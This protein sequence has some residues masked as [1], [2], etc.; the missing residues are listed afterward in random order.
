MN[1]FE[2]LKVT[3]LENDIVRFEYCPDKNFSDQESLFVA[4]KVAAINQL[5]FKKDKK[6][7]FK[8]SDFVFSFD[9]NDPLNTLEVYLNDIVVY[10]YKEIKNSGELPVPNKTPYV[11][12]LMDSPRLLIPSEGY[13]NENSGYE[14]EENVKDL[15]LLLCNKDYL[16]L[17]RQ[18]IS[19]TGKNELPRIKNFGLFSSRYYK[20]SQQSAMEMIRNYEKH[21]IPL[22]TF[23]LDTDWRDQE[24]TQGT[25]YKVNEKLFPNIQDFFRF[26]HIHNLQIMMNDH[27][28]PLNKE[29]KILDKDEIKFRSSNLT[30]LFIKGLDGW[31]YDR[32]W[33]CSLNSVH[34]HIAP[35]TLGN[36]LYN[37]VTKQFHL[38]YVIDQEVY[39]RSLVMNNI[40][41]IEN[42]QYKTILDSRSHT[43]SLQWSG[44]T[45]SDEQTLRN[46][47]INLNKCANN[48]LAFYSSDIGG[49]M[50]NP[51][52]NQYIRWIEY[53]SF[54]PVLR[55][56]CTCSVKKFRE[57]WNYDKKTLEISRNY[58]NIRYKLLNSFY[59]AAYK[60]VES[61]LGVCS[62]LYLYNPDDKKCYKE[63]TSFMI[64]DSILVSPISGAD[65]P[66]SV[67]KSNFTNKLRVT[68]YPNG[69]FKGPKSYTKTVSSFADVNKFFKSVKSK[70]TKAKK[71]SFRFKG[72]LYFKRD[73]QLSLFNDVSAKVS[74]NNK[75]VF[76]DF[77]WHYPTFNEIAKLK[78]NKHYALKV[79]VVQSRKL[80]TVNLVYYK[81]LKNNKTKIYLPEGEWFNMFHKNVYQ[82]KRY[83]KE[84]FKIDETPVFVKAGSLLAL[85]KTV[86]NISKMSLKNIVYDYYTSKK[87]DKTDYFYE[88][89]GI[90]TGYQI[91]E[92][93]KN[94]YR[95]HF[96]KDRYIIELKGNEKLLE[97]EIKYRNVIFKAHIR[98]NETIDKV[99][100]NGEPVKFRRHDHSKKAIPFLDNEFAKDS[101]TLTFKFKQ[102][103][104]DNYVIELVIRNK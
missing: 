43:Y 64:G 24:E 9:E 54:S 2:N 49:H 68:I 60:N 11:F 91:G 12:P 98:D 80:K 8:Y 45:F 20:Y 42:G 37:D 87:V 103:I 16:K 56:H 7:S 85:Y 81:L 77:D 95:T 89:D 84:R 97:D 5:E 29:S 15:Y 92:Y 55:P 79:E 69:E 73:Y 53:G 46:E 47:I 100:I 66:R 51:N 44:D 48:M 41:N 90:T 19:L 3:L 23:I 18:F 50:G 1:I 10:K 14:L 32:N 101:K 4:R 59:T 35:E 86:D 63:E 27:P 13:S 96:D 104:K 22:D 102:V 52:K 62:P 65:K 88:D 71:F 31:W 26:A 61:G 75:E 70:N 28:L 67:N 94:E 34:E 39:E 74:I 40:T 93:R 58:I 17:R 82:G 76:N 78:K 38:G 99:L 21:K 72:D 83:I 25:G 6:V 33:I 57:P 30:K 36:Y